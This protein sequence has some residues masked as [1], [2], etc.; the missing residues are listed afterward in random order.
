MPLIDALRSGVDLANAMQQGVITGAQ[1]RYAYPMTQADLEKMRLANQYQGIIN[2]YQPEKSRLSNESLGLSNAYQSIIN[3]YQ[4][5]KSDLENQQAQANL[6]FTPLKYA[7]EAQNSMRNSSRFGGAYQYL[8]SIADLP[9]AQ[10]S[11]YLADPDNYNQY[12][13]MIGQLHDSVRT[14]G[15]S[16]V[17][18][19]ALLKK[20][21]LDTIADDVVNG[22]PSAPTVTK[23]APA[24][25]SAGGLGAPIVNTSAAPAQANNSMPPINVNIPQSMPMPTQAQPAAPVAPM[26]GLTSPLP[27]PSMGATIPPSMPPVA[28]MAPAAAPMVPQAPQA[29]ARPVMGAPN[30]NAPLMDNT[31]PLSA[32]SAQISD[33]YGVSPESANS[34]A[35]DAKDPTLT[36]KDRQQLGF[37]MRANEQLAGSKITNQALSA[38]AY[39]KLIMQNQDRFAPAFQNAAKYAGILGQGKLT[40][41][42]FKSEHPAEYA[43]YTWVVNDLIPALGQNIRRIEGLAATDGQ[44][45][46]LNEMY[47]SVLDWKSDPKMA[48]DNINK[49]MKLFNSQAKSVLEAAQPVY[50]GTLERLYGVQPTQQSYIGGNKQKALQSLS[51][52]EIM[53]RL[54]GGK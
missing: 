54:Q 27:M 25:S 22:Q 5:Q 2:Q 53:R 13:E 10:R 41:D 43:D 39:D 46:A 4:P 32:A 6:N 14:Q 30:Q 29:P 40:L 36:P 11:I 20:V 34:V 49:T 33:K 52:D 23:G 7:I 35:N 16:T 12:M 47:H 37:Q 9:A 3:K 38:I 44:R 1:A 31:P 51:N 45:E 15:Q 28:P 26:G 42:K 21:G 19:P 48:L 24:Q 8:K 17:I 50:P 18:T